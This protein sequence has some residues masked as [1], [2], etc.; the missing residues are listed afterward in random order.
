NLPCFLI[1]YEQ[2]DNSKNRPSGISAARI[3]EDHFNQQGISIS[4]SLIGHAD[5][6]LKLGVNNKESYATL[7]NTD[8]WPSQV[9][10]INITV[11]KSKFTSDS[12]LLAVRYV[13]LQYDDEFV[14]EKIKQNL[15]SVENIRR[16]QY[17]FQRRTN[18]FRFINRDVN[19]Y[20]STLKLGRISIG[21][22]LCIITPFLTA[23]FERNETFNT[24][25]DD[26]D[27]I[28]EVTAD[29]ASISIDDDPLNNLE[30]LLA[31][32]IGCSERISANEFVKLDEDIPVF[33]KWNNVK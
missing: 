17:R 24:V 11:S 14:K 29:S 8:K 2:A 10:S 1:E 33:D 19:E 27:E 4:F 31:Y 3:I 13:P 28:R 23:G 7:I 30:F 32:A 21:N 16:I 15:Q 12:F 9:N 5:N 18:D 25:H 22:A 20:N 26:A 6:K